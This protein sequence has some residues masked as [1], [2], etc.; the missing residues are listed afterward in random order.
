[1]HL[2]CLC[3]I[4][5]FFKSSVAWWLLQRKDRRNFTRY[6]RNPLIET[7][8]N[9][10]SRPATSFVFCVLFTLAAYRKISNFRDIFWPHN[11]PLPCMSETLSS[12]HSFDIKTAVLHTLPR[13]RLSFPHLARGQP[14][15]S[16]LA[17]TA[18]S[19]SYFV[20]LPP[21]LPSLPAVLSRPPPR[22]S[23]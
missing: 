4:L 2:C 23:P 14:S 8:P 22:C 10:T 20:V 11:L 6:S 21:S 13:R 3:T 9:L 19:L 17:A 7:H 15:S 1:M 18:S 16:S 12:I 5:L